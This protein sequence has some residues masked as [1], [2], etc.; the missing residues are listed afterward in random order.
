MT[1]RGEVDDRAGT[2]FAQ[3]MQHLVAIADVAADEQVS[4]VALDRLEIAEIARV[5]KL[6]QVDDRFVGAIEP[7]EN[8]IGAYET[9]TPGHQNHSNSMRR[10][11]SRSFLKV[12]DF[13]MR[14]TPASRRRSIRDTTPR[15]WPGP[16][17]GESTARTPSRRR[18]ARSKRTSREHLPAEAARIP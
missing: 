3:Q 1:F 17:S 4:S 12:A 11:Q 14:L 9:R 15:T 18:G 8:E 10:G 7:V 5:G 2:V 13:I 6:V 16:R